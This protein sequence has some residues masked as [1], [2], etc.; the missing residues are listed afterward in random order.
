MGCTDQRGAVRA[1]Q[2]RSKK[3]VLL[4]LKVLLVRPRLSRPPWRCLCWRSSRDCS[5]GSR[6]SCDGGPKPCAASGSCTRAGAAHMQC[7]TNLLPSAAHRSS[8][9]ALS[10]GLPWPSGATASSSER[11]VR[12]DVQGEPAQRSQVGL[13]YSTRQACDTSTNSTQASSTARGPRSSWDY[14]RWSRAYGSP[15]FATPVWRRCT[16]AGAAPAVQQRVW[17]PGPAPAAADLSQTWGVGAAARLLLTV[18]ALAVVHCEGRGRVHHPGG[19]AR[20]G[21]R[22]RRARRYAQQWG[23]VRGALP[24]VLA[25]QQAALF[26]HARAA[27]QLSHSELRDVCH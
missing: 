13:A 1:R 5:T 11:P 20:V 15:P 9:C 10:G 24:E 19:C 12:D 26:M 22:P 3:L 17:L 2:P 14:T 21:Q 8:C 4:L 25:P 27:L 18:W 6:S 23:Q 7:S 16:R